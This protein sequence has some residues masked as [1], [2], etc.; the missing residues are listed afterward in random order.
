MIVFLFGTWGSGKSFVGNL[1]QKECGLLH[2]EADIHFNKKMLNALHAR[3]FHELDLAVYYNQVVS[4]IF[5]FKK[6][7]NNFIV[8]QGIY[9]E[10]YRRLIY[11]IFEPEIHFVW[12]KTD[13][14]KI[15][16]LRLNRRSEQTGNPITG[17]VLEYMQNYWE[18][19]QVPHEVLLNGPL[20]ERHGREMLQ[21]WGLCL[22]WE[23]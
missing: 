7:A 11:E 5:S 19:P 22:G 6:R 20:L 9:E 10:R 18:A 17:E 8:S 21:S 2:M 15:Q 1:F 14:K 13:N 12:V 23:V 16:K 3:T 4:D